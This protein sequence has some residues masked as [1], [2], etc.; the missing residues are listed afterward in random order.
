M[1]HSCRSAPGH[2]AW[3]LAITAAIAVATCGTVA[4]D[5]VVADTPGT[6]Y[7]HAEPQG[8][9]G[10]TRRDDSGEGRQSS[11]PSRPDAVITVRVYERT[12]G[13]RPFVGDEP[14]VG[15]DVTAE[16]ETCPDGNDRI[17]ALHIGG[18]RYAVDGECPAER[19]MPT[20]DLR[21]DSDER[22]AEAELRCDPVTRRCR[23]TGR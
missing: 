17:G 12:G 10:A 20:D 18:R 1:L 4:A 9:Q 15:I 19:V 3:R 11:D 21:K 7:S 2:R 16:I 6:R 23:I 22:P 13:L 5:D 8:W 14:L